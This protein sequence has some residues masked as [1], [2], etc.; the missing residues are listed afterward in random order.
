MT[1][2][3]L[4]AATGL[5][6][7]GAEGSAAI[8]ITPPSSYVQTGSTVDVYVEVRN[9]TTGLGT[10]ELRI[11]YDPVILE[12]VGVANMG[13]L[14]STGRNPSCHSEPDTND[15]HNPA[16][17]LVWYV[18]NTS[19]NLPPGPTGSGQLAQIRF[20][21]LSEGDSPLAFQDLTGEAGSRITGLSSG[22]EFGTAIEITDY[23]QGVIRV[24]DTAPSDD[25]GGGGGGGGGNSSSRASTPT[26]VPGA[27]TPVVPAA[28]GTPMPALEDDVYDRNC[29]G[30]GSCS[31]GGGAA[32]PGGV[33][34]SG[35]TSGSGSGSGA[36]TGAPIAGYGPQPQEERV[37]ATA[38]RNLVIAGG[39]LIFFGVIIAGRKREA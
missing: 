18:C 31:A 8:Q 11:T 28:A 14:A 38:L 34:G 32:A 15:D 4:V 5:R 29:A 37:S 13:F 9:L 2:V 27:L 6:R 21:G 20:K 36:G 24:G 12:F 3:A 16:T 22:D 33:L 30:A 10:Y 39:L 23:G 25:G 1:L 35:T 17:G 19:T 7:A 26:K